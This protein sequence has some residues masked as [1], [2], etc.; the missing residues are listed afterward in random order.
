[1][2]KTLRILTTDGRQLKEI[3]WLTHASDSIYYGLS[4]VPVHSSYHKDG[5]K[6]WKIEA[7]SK[8]H[9]TVKCAP[10]KSFTGTRQLDY[11][12]LSK[13]S[14]SG[15]AFKA[16]KHDRLLILD[17]RTRKEDGLG[18]SVHLVE[19]GKRDLMPAFNKGEE[20]HIFT[21]FDPWVVIAVI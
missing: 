4:D 16:R 13:I 18:I 5:T 17:T 9:G 10:L 2:A 8:Y 12:A 6:H 3:F 7:P 21:E 14:G 11:F 15:K 19:A 1:M 20:I